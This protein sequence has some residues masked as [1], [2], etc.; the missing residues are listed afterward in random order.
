MK[1]EPKSIRSVCK[2][3]EAKTR[4]HAG[5]VK[6]NCIYAGCST[7]RSVYTQV[8]GFLSTVYVFYCDLATYICCYNVLG[9]IFG[10]WLLFLCSGYSYQRSAYCESVLFGERSSIET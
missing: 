4:I 9:S 1:E 8:S 5:L 7:Y 6:E 2:F 10:I 3:S